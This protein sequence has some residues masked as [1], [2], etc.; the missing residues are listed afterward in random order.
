MNIVQHKIFTPPKHLQ[1]YIRFYWTLDLNGSCVVD[2][3][4][5][6]YA[7]RYPRLVVQ[8]YDGSSAVTNANG[9]LPVSYLGG[10]N[11]TPYACG[12]HPCAKILGASFYP[13]TLRRFFGFDVVDMVDELPDLTNFAP[14]WWVA[15]M[16][17]ETD[18]NRKLAKLSEF[19][20]S[21]LLHAAPRDSAIQTGWEKISQFPASCNIMSLAKDFG[22]S[23]R[24]LERRFKLTIGYSPKQFLRVSRFEIALAELKA[25]IDPKISD[26]AY[27]LGYADQSHLIREFKE[28]SGHTPTRYLNTGKFYEEN[29][30]FIVK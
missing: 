7:R 21:R 2:Q 18:E 27:R 16:I 5:W 26:I 11:L 15:S 22:I 19:F 10:L 25:R 6:M 14:E 23:P 13:H 17:E 28:F 1:P 29:G 30:A 4:F 3:T 24:Q 8:H 20:T 12:I 9:Y